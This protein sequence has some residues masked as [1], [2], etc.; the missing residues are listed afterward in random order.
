MPNHFYH[1]IEDGRTF[2]PFDSPARCSSDAASKPEDIG[3]KIIIS[4]EVT[5]RPVLGL[6]SE[7]TQLKAA[8]AYG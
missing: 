6:I 5:E 1:F 8:T 3:K 2:G 4:V 7:A